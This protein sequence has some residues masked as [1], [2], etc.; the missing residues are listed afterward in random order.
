MTPQRGQRCFPAGAFAPE[1][2]PTN[3]QL[4]EYFDENRARY[5]RPERRTVRYASFTEEAVGDLP[6]VTQAQIRR[7]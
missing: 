2:D 7:A 1:G 6:P 3:A 4:Q 5:I